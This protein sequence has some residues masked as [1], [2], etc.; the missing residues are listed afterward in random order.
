MVSH[1][2]RE[3]IGREG[4]GPGT[5]ETERDS[6]GG[7]DLSPWRESA[8]YSFTMSTVSL[9]GRSRGETMVT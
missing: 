1:A 4:K 2:R 8:E 3:N 7:G 9:T 5:R 6:T